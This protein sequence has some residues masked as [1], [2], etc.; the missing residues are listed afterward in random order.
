MKKSIGF[1]GGSYF[2]DGSFDAGAGSAG[3]ADA[4]AGSEAAGIFRWHVEGSGH[5]ATRCMVQEGRS[6]STHKIW[7]GLP[8]RIFL[9]GHSDT[10]N[11][12]WERVYD[13]GRDGLGR[14]RKKCLQVS[15]YSIVEGEAD[16]GQRHGERRHLDVDDRDDDG[17]ATVQGV[18]L[19]PKNFE[20]AVHIQIWKFRP[21]MA[22]I[23]G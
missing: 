18:D 11:R 14:R 1:G 19:R 22:A 16:D 5:G 3:C 7:N 23:R 12:R 9:V 21:W 15:T 8:G 10:T 17:W 4:G 2:D 20:V 6:T 13:H